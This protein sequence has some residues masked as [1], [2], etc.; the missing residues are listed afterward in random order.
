MT[1]NTMSISR[2]AMVD[3]M[4][5]SKNRNLKNQFDF[6]QK[7]IETRTG[8]VDDRHNNQIIIRFKS[9]YKSRWEAKPPL[10]ER[11]YYRPSDRHMG[12]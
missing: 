2:R 12:W 7:E 8:C 5:I 11:V 10:C 4:N 1:S 3:I 6:L 9:D